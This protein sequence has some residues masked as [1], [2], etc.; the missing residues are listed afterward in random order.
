METLFD[1]K[2]ESD[3]IVF[4]D[5]APHEIVKPAKLSIEAQAIVKEIKIKIQQNLEKKE[6]SHKESGQKGITPFEKDCTDK[7]RI[8]YKYLLNDIIERIDFEH[9][10][11]KFG[12]L[13]RFELEVR[14]DMYDAESFVNIMDHSYHM[15]DLTNKDEVLEKA[16]EIINLLGDSTLTSFNVLKERKLAMLQTE[17]SDLASFQFQLENEIKDNA[18]IDKIMKNATE[19]VRDSVDE[20]EMGEKAHAILEL[21]LRLVDTKKE[22]WTWFYNLQKK[23]RS[24]LQTE[25]GK[26]RI[27]T[28]SSSQPVKKQKTATKLFFVILTEVDRALFH[29][30]KKERMAKEYLKEEGDRTNV[31]F[32]PLQHNASLRKNKEIIMEGKKIYPIKV[33]DIQCASMQRIYSKY[34]FDK[35]RVDIPYDEDSLTI[36][37]KSMRDKA[38]ERAGEYAKCCICLKTIAVDEVASFVCCKQNYRE[39][40]QSRTQVCRDCAEKHVNKHYQTLNETQQERIYD[41]DSKS[42]NYYPKDPVTRETIIGVITFLPVPPMTKNEAKECLKECRPEFYKFWK[43][44]EKIYTCF[45]ECWRA[46]P[47]FVIGEMSSF[48]RKEKIFNPTHS[49]PN[50]VCV[51]SYI[52]NKIF[53]NNGNFVPMRKMFALAS[54]N[55]VTELCQ[56][57]PQENVIKEVKGNAKLFE[58]VEKIIDH[59]DQKRKY[60]CLNRLSHENPQLS[61][62]VQSIREGF[63]KVFMEHCTIDLIENEMSDDDDGTQ[64]LY[65]PVN[66]WRL[67]PESV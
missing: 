58:D 60:K 56:T 30:A 53:N 7:N 51:E 11:P 49:Q 24:M 10:H 4:I 12:A 18:T 45:E 48:G 66:D 43:N 59:V 41:I 37:V 17:S 2:F 39:H 20:N 47:P 44:N 14:H 22:V 64:P 1:I 25:N 55:Y 33:F 62:V 38:I 19:M 50:D 13:F 28:G 35:I 65:S 42:T 21:G 54:R 57:E 5:I 31:I 8:L 34:E 63:K 46:C 9:D 29:R 27:S 36:D 26:K 16:S 40:D 32:Y 3:N 23:K 67:P 6:Y 15:M 61:V 52:S